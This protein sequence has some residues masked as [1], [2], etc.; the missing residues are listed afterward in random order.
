MWLF[1]FFSFLF[2]AVVGSFLNVCIYRVPTGRS[3]V[4]PNSHCPLCGASI[5]PY[6][7]IPILSFLLLRGKCRAC[8]QPISIRY[9][10]VELLNA[11]LFLLIFYTFGFG[12]HAFIYAAFASALVVI[13]F[14]DLDH[15]IIPDIISYPGI[16]IGLLLPI[17]FHYAKMGY[18]WYPTVLD[19]LIGAAI[20][21]FPLY[22]FALIYFAI[23]KK[24]GLG[25]GDAKLLAWI[26]AFLGWKSVLLT[27][28]LGSVL[29]SIIS[30]ILIFKYKKSRKTL[31]PFGP[32]LSFGALTTLLF[33]EQIITGWLSLTSFLYE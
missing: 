12:I 4:Y 9:P 24:E 23:T 13:S 31:I 21:F 20:G 5:K 28:L 17:A 32:F 6:D 3:I 16:A 11:L 14:I 25:L 2:G 26:G 29:G 19:A 33:G 22:F 15:Q 18:L 10:I 1:Y 7:N 8:H 27:I 30:L